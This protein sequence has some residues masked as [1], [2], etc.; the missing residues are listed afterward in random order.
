MSKNTGGSSYPSPEHPV[1]YSGT[2]KAFSHVKKIGSE[3]NNTAS[4]EREKARLARLMKAQGRSLA[5]R[6]SMLFIRRRGRL[7]PKFIP[8]MTTMPGYAI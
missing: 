6:N 7:L 3:Y 4:G 1:S 5:S 8:S 2:P